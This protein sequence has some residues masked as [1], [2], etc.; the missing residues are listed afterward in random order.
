MQWFLILILFTF[1]ECEPV[2]KVEK[3]TM[4]CRDN[5]QYI[6]SRSFEH[7]H[8][9]AEVCDPTSIANLVGNHLPQHPN[10]YFRGLEEQKASFIQLPFK[11]YPNPAT[12]WFRG[13][14][15]VC[16]SFKHPAFED[17][18]HLIAGLGETDYALDYYHGVSL[19]SKRL[20]VY[21][22]RGIAI[23]L[24]K[25]QK[26]ILLLELFPP[27]DIESFKSGIYFFEAPRELPQH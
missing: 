15:V 16:L 9:L 22:E 21:P 18:E 25:N 7:W 6:L 5:L 1:C 17:P 13:E 20:R 2:N 11:G 12:L 4:N 10:S 24:S 3:K 27:T 8:G 14:K 19:K 26:N 23:G